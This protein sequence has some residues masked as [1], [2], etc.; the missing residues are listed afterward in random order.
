MSAIKLLLL[1]WSRSDDCKGAC[2]VRRSYCGR[3][4]TA[5]SCILDLKEDLHLVTKDEG[6]ANKRYSASYNGRYRALSCAPRVR[7]AAEASCGERRSLF[8]AVGNLIFLYEV[9]LS[10]SLWRGYSWC[11]GGA[12]A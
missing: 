9:T 12:E 5:V 1:G 8:I 4:S 7:G 10:S 6:L 3:F 2:Q 11:Y